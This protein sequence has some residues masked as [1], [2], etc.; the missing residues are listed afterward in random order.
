MSNW[1]KIIIVLVCFAIAIIGF[2]I[3]LPS[4]FRRHDK[5]LHSLFYFLAAG[6]LNIL[7]ANRNI[8]RHVLIF[9]FLYVFGMAIEYAQAYSNQFTRSRIHGR[10]DP[11]DV[12]ANLNGLLAF[13]AVW[14]VYMGVTFVFSKQK[15]QSADKSVGG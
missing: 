1:T 4:A 3:K 12:S 5:E 8:L 13:S 6:F 2:M 15:D 9:A 10:Y 14:L 7:F 11:E